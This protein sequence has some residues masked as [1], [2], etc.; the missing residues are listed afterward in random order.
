MDT[1]VLKMSQVKFTKLFLVGCLG[2]NV[3]SFLL[4]GPNSDT[5]CSARVW[6]FNFFITFALAPLL[7]KTYRLHCIFN[8]TNLEVVAITMERLVAMCVCLLAVDAI[9]MGV[10]QGTMGTGFERVTSLGNDQSY[11]EH[12]L[13]KVSPIAYGLYSYKA[14]IITIGCVLSFITR[15]VDPAFSESK[16][17]MV[18]LY[19]R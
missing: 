13:C 10:W 12:I 16:A 1:K 9:L 11:A 5:L 3:T 14:V 2:V 4:V 7:A 17:L 8:N 15:D 18:M 19:V 6:M